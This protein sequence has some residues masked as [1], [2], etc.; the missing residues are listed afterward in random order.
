MSEITAVVPKYGLENTG[1]ISFKFLIDAEIP[2]GIVSKPFG[3]LIRQNKT[4]DYVD[5]FKLV[6]NE[7]GAVGNDG[8]KRWSLNL[9][10]K[11]QL[12]LDSSADEPGIV[13]ILSATPDCVILVPLEDLEPLEMAC[14]SLGHALDVFFHNGALTTS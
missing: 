5:P 3:L 9:Y 11:G 12:L 7:P 10:S 1:R 8:V 2:R 6:R 14:K 13:D 4:E